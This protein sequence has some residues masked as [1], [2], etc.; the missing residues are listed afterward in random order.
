MP[1]LPLHGSQNALKI[2]KKDVFWEVLYFTLA[3]LE[4]TLGRFLES[5]AN[6]NARKTRNLWKFWQK[7]RIGYRSDNDITHTCRPLVPTPSYIKARV[8]SLK[9]YTGLV[10]RIALTTFIDMNEKTGLLRFKL[11]LLT[12]RSFELDFLKY[13]CEPCK[14]DSK[15]RSHAF[16]MGPVFRWDPGRGG[17][18]IGEESTG[19]T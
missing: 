1:K 11:W 17:G 14:S 16:L 12:F 6:P 9:E 18:V 19:K 7:L 3:G 15:F 8:M 2:A 13:V 4:F 5:W 10:F